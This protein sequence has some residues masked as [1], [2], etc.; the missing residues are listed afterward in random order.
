MSNKQLKVPTRDGAYLD[1]A[2]TPALGAVQ[3]LG[4]LALGATLAISAKAHRYAR[5]QP[6]DG[7]H[8]QPFQGNINHQLQ[9][10]LT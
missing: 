8:G 9:P 7:I 5:A 6:S 2:G 10:M 1:A 3:A 4:T